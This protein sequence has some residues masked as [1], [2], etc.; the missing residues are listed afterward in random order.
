VATF[1]NPIEELIAEL[2]RFVPASALKADAEKNLR[3]LVQSTFQRLDLV[4]REEF[5]AQKE[6]LKRTRDRVESLE[7]EID[8]LTDLLKSVSDNK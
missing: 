4:S 5:D 1:N 6:V 3:T 8:S 2:N 7:K